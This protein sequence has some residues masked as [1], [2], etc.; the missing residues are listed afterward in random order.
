MMWQVIIHM[1]FVPSALPLASID[2]LTS[3]GPA[4]RAGDRCG[5]LAAEEIDDLAGNARAHRRV[6]ICLSPGLPFRPR[7]LSFP[8]RGWRFACPLLLVG[9]KATATKSV[10]GIGC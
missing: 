1:A 10:L 5:W 8:T 6:V 9:Q 2:R 3:S 4:R 7:R